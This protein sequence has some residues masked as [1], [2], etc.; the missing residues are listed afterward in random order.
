LDK[1]VQLT[2]AEECLILLFDQEGKTVFQVGRNRKQEDI[3]ALASEPSW[4]IHTKM[5]KVKLPLP[6]AVAR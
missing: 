1:L 6:E 2:G 4:T 5:R 3:I